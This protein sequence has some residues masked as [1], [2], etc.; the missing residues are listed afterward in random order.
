MLLAVVYA[1]RHVR[2]KVCVR[3]MCL[4][5]QHHQSVVKQ[6]SVHEGGGQAAPVRVTKGEIRLACVVQPTAVP[7]RHP[8][9][10]FFHPYSAS[11]HHD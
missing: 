8:S 11:H 7:V 10:C 4:P 5:L 9:L 6:G 3:R 2:G 1:C